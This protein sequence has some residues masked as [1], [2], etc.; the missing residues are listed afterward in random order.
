MVNG[1][2]LEDARDGR[3]VLLDT[4]GEVDMKA[5]PRAGIIGNYSVTKSEFS[6]V[7]L[8]G[9]RALLG[10]RQRTLPVT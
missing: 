3:R 9:V 5:F 4:A 7:G 2:G 6:F 8:L 1:G 10:V